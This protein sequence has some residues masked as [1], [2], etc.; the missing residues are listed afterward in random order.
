M[1]IWAVCLAVLCF[2]LRHSWQLVQAL[3][4]G[5]NFYGFDIDA[6]SGLWILVPI[7]MVL[8]LM[9]ILCFGYWCQFL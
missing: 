8:I 7:S 2:S 3:K 5:A 1:H 6:I 9:P 4:I